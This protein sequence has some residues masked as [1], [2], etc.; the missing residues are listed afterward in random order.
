MT[1]LEIQK[2]HR[3][4]TNRVNT[5]LFSEK[6][7]FNKL[8]VSKRN[9]TLSENITSYLL[10]ELSHTLCHERISKIGNWKI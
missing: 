7:K 6:S 3:T 9:N 5:R 4:P 2:R 8:F 10:F 1:I